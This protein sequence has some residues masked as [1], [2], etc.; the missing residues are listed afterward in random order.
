MQWISTI[1]LAGVVL[2]V[3]NARGQE[4]PPVCTVKIVVSGPREARPT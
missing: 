4:P 3:A 2:V 1:A